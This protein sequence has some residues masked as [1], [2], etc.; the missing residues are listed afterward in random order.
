LKN[1]TEGVDPMV[2]MMTTSQDTLCFHEILKEPGK[3]EF[4]KTMKDEINNHNNNKN[5]VPIRRQDIPKGHKVIPSVWAMRRKRRL[6][7][8]TVCKWKARLNIDSSNQVHGMNY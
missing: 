6:D 7:D 4:V 3:M 8:G 5:W 2:L 1:F